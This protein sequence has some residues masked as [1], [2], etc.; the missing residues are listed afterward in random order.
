MGQGPVET[1][2]TRGKGVWVRTLQPTTPLRCV[3]TWP[4]SNLQLNDRKGES[5]QGLGLDRGGGHK[6]RGCFIFVKAENLRT[7]D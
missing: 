4:E 1:E 7:H 3:S 2:A 6:P 5:P